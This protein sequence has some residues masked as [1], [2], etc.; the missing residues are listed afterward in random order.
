MLKPV[1][2]FR[3]LAVQSLN[4]F[5]YG[6][7]PYPVRTKNGMV[8]GGGFVYPEINFTLPPVIINKRTMPDIKS[9]YK[10]II[11]AV[12]RRAVE[13]H[14]PGFV[15][16]LELLPPTTINAKWGI[17]IHKIVRDT[18]FDYEAKYGVKSALRCTPND[19][20]ELV[21]PPVMR[22][23]KILDNMLETFEKTAVD[24]A[25][26]L[27][28]E[29][30]GGKEIHDDALLNCDL[31]RIIFALGVLA[32][33]DVRRLWSEIVAIAER[34]KSIPA[35]DTGCGF[36]NTALALAE[37]GLIP[38]VLAAV[39]RV[40]VI[41]RTLA[42]CEVGAVGPGK[43]CAYEGP[44]IKA[45]AGIPI[46]MEGKSAACA[47]LSPLGNIAACVCDLWSNESVQNINLLSAPAPVVSMEQLIY[48]C[49]L[50]NVVSS[51][52]YGL[53]FRDW[54]AESDAMM[55]PQAYVIK[56]DVVFKISS[57]LVKVPDPLGRVRKACELAIAVIK[58]GIEKGE[59]L[60]QSKEVRWLKIMESQLEKVPDDRDDLW[61]CVKKEIEAGTFIPAEYEL[62]DG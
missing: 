37:Q 35:G 18:M 27:S 36:A 50:M 23:G 42:A 20:R 16:E 61:A 15:V 43:D 11:E 31:K 52:G 57:E 59:L 24:G 56:P 44:Y 8:I 21:R 58:S 60:L 22:R 45:I 53:K 32:V 7:A 62:E 51:K 49:R 34:T 3:K 10:E 14:A 17:E 13:L 41:P 55:D 40:A 2:E 28:V 47:H 1:K 39:V 4:D 30:V 5:V 26:F 38:K 9:Q 54:L 29:S 46:S 48:D 33:T 12:Y 6:S 25:D 19:S